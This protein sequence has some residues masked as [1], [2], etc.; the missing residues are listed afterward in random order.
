MTQRS[1]LVGWSPVVV[2]RAGGEVQVQ[3]WDGDRLEVVTDGRWGLQI[4]QRKGKPEVQIG[5]S[6]VVRLP[7]GSAV[8]VY[9]GKSADVRDVQG[10]LTVYAGGGAYLR[11]VR[12]IL[13]VSA[14]GLADIDAEY[15]EGG[16]V[17]CVAGS[18]LRCAIRH[19]RDTRLLVSDRGGRWEGVIGSGQ[20]RLRLEA[21]GDVTVVT[22]EP[23]VAQPPHYILGQ[24]E[25]QP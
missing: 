9:S 25:P 15:V 14:G 3:G 20:A 24:I 11:G 13:H 19:L 8:T 22:N 5:E 12:A 16:D 6:G 17:R 10:G 18:N 7:V 1:M 4:G 21:G 23:V 2:I